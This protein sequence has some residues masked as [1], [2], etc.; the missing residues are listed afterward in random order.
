MSDPQLACLALSLAPLTLGAIWALVDTASRAI[1]GADTPADPVETFRVI[2]GHGARL[3]ALIPALVLA[4]AA[5]LF[6]WRVR[7]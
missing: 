2:A 6:G 4:A 3:L 1:G 5:A 7:P